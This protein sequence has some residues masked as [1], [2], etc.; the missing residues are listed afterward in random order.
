M[1]KYT[2][3]ANEGVLLCEYEDTAMLM[4]DEK[5]YVLNST[6]TWLWKNLKGKLIEQL[7]EEFIENQCLEDI[8]E[9]INC[10]FEKMVS[11]WENYGL[12]KRNSI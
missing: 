2:Y 4:Y 11:E 10:D 1:S 8:R 3:N 6:A 12:V 5:I 9:E 7:A